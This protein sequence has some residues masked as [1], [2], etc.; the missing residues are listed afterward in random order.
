MTTEKRE[1]DQGNIFS[2]AT[3]REFLLAALSHNAVEDAVIAMLHEHLV[4][5]RIHPS[6]ITENLKPLITEVLDV[7]TAEDWHYVSC[8]LIEEACEALEV[9]AMGNTTAQPDPGELR[10]ELGH[11]YA[12]EPL[13]PSKYRRAW[14]LI[15]TISKLTGIS[16]K[17][18]LADARVD[19]EAVRADDAVRAS[20]SSGQ[21]PASSD[22][23]DMVLDAATPPIVAAQQVLR[24]MMDNGGAVYIE[25]TKGNEVE[26]WVTGLTEDEVSIQE[27]RNNQST[28]IRLTDIETLTETAVSVRQI[29]RVEALVLLDKIEGTSPLARKQVA[30]ILA[31]NVGCSVTQIVAKQK[32]EE[33]FVRKVINDFNE[34]GLE[35]LESST[36]TTITLDKG[37]LNG[38][39]SGIAIA[40]LALIES[41]DPVTIAVNTGQF[42]LLVSGLGLACLALEGCG[43]EYAGF[44]EDYKRLTDQVVVQLPGE[45]PAVRGA[46]QRLAS[47][48]GRDIGS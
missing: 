13:S 4:E 30:V 47:R 40:R 22:L 44:V 27:F 31:S 33:S 11:L 15:R 46:R 42:N 41:D 10:E 14:L 32:V 45:G 28:Y 37:Q 12:H 38:L 36:P 29:S 9:N 8:K 16:R 1:S 7:A 48:E 24:H 26:G 35:S 34:R 20:R 43:D 18:I 19:A 23:A 3:I 21:P 25:D 6:V 5:G 17:T 2:V 39:A